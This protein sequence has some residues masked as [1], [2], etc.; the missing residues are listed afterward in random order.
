MRFWRRRTDDI[1]EEIATHLAMAAADREERG[2]S[3]EEARRS[4][5]R[6]FGNPLLVRETTQRMWG[7]EWVDRITQDLRFAWRQMRRSPTFALMV[8]ATLAVG[9]GAT[10]AMFT[11]VERVLLQNLSYPAPQRLVLLQESGRRGEQEWTPWPDI[12][13]WALKTRSFEDIGFY[14]SASGR[15]FLEG[16]SAAEQI[17]QLMVSTN[18]F[19]VL[20]VKP[21]MGHGFVDSKSQRFAQAGD[22][23]TVVLSDSAWRDSF[24]GRRDILGGVVRIS[25]QPFTVVG[26]MPR[27]FSFP[28]NASQPQ[29]WTAVRFRQSDDTRIQPKTT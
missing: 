10:A 5:K 3:S 15:L 26:V 27:G 6:E 8:I 19:S 18:L 12:E 2:E 23:N 24:G 1:D 4:A 29:V 20:G 21:Q 28:W 7:W 17:S 13:Q 25:G 16:D 22:E 11:I 9:L 14:I